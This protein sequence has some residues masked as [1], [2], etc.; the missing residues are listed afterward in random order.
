MSTNRALA[1]LALLIAGPLVG[2]AGNGRVPLPID[3]IARSEPY[4]ATAREAGLAPPASHSISH[5]LVTLLLPQ[6]QLVREAFAR[7]EWPHWNPTVHG[8][9]PLAAAGQAAPLWPTTLL[10]LLLPV[11]LGLALDF[12]LRLLLAGLGATLL[13][14]DRGVQPLAAVAAGVGYGLGGFTVFF[15]MWPLGAAMATL[16]WVWL[17]VRRLVRRP[18]RRELVL[19]SLALWG[20]IVAGHPESLVHV[21]AIGCGGGLVELLAK[22]RSAPTAE[23]ARPV[24]AALAAGA[25]AISLGAV[26]LVPL[27]QVLPQSAAWAHRG[28]R[29]P[30]AAEARAAGEALLDAVL[31]F[32]HGEVGADGP[33]FPSPRLPWAGAS[34]GGLLLALAAAG[35]VVEGRRAVPMLGATA[36]GLLLAAR[37]S[38]LWELAHQLPLLDRAINDRLVALGL[39]GLSLLAAHGANALLESGAHRRRVVVSAALATAVCVAVV[40]TWAA[41]S[42]DAPVLVALAATVTAGGLAVALAALVPAHRAGLAVAVLLVLAAGERWFEVRHLVAGRD[43]R[44]LTLAPPILAE[45]PLAESPTRI[46]AAGR[47]LTPNLAGYAGLED[48]RGYDPVALAR[49]ESVRRWWSERQPAWFDRIDDLEAPA[50]DRLGV[51]Y[52]LTRDRW[53]VAAGWE[54]LARA[55]GF[56]LL[57]N[58]ETLERAFVPHVVVAAGPPALADGAGTWV[59]LTGTELGPGRHANPAG[60]VAV[61]RIAPG[62]LELT[63]ELAADGWVVV[64]EPSWNGWRA[65]DAASGEPRRLVVADHAFLAVRLPGGSTRT[66]LVWRPPGFRLWAAVSVAAAVLLAVLW[67]GGRSGHRPPAILMRRRGTM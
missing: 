11:G 63:T 43:P 9:M 39:L 67:V 36:I 52:A 19:L 45:I 42:L 22:R 66:R 58:R 46:V 31:P 6:R 35:A 2:V 64:S 49:F 44:Y 16:P 18:G 17:A 24:G 60:F 10:T 61:R 26:F 37:A 57:A 13:A 7:G 28:T 38:P 47:L 33:S 54:I 20:T 51:R 65:Q 12:A 59:S 48:L 4:A 55:D 5:E 8:G 1:L 53:A 27:V 14:R 29:P 41:P 23:L 3:L 21:V 15:A 56:R 30:P 32:R 40:A 34:I 62:A 25:L 50:L